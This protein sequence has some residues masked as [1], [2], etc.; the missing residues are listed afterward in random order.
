MIHLVKVNIPRIN[1]QRYGI[2]LEDFEVVGFSVYQKVIVG[3]EI[4]LLDLD[5]YEVIA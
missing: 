1:C 5:E 4:Y 3:T 2:L